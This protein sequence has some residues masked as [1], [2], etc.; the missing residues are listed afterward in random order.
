MLCDTLKT[1]LK[2]K[3]FRFLLF[4]DLFL[5]VVLDVGRGNDEQV[6]A[7]DLHRRLLR[8]D[9][10]EGNLDH[11]KRHFA[12]H[13][14]YG[15]TLKFSVLFIFTQSCHTFLQCLENKKKD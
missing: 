5:F 14:F 3:L 13:A 15:K 7:L 12:V 6:D 11:Q 4:F 8:Q 1:D 10:Q 2:P 9:V